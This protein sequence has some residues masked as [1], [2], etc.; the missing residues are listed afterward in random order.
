MHL[1]L[2]DPEELICI[3]IREYYTNYPWFLWKNICVL[4]FELPFP[5]LRKC[6]IACIFLAWDWRT[7]SSYFCSFYRDY[8]GSRPSLFDGIEEGINRAASS[9]YSN[10]EISEHDNDTAMDGLQDKVNILKRVCL[11]IWIKVSYDFSFMFIIFLTR[12]NGLISL[13]T[14]YNRYT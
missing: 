1:V 14:D 11:Y 9:S 8:R 3:V 7:N 6:N 12:S 13:Y 10:L 2:D 5:A 4:V